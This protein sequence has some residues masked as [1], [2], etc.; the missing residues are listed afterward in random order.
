MNHHKRILI[1]LS[2]IFMLGGCSS[3]I[4]PLPTAEPPTLDEKWKEGTP[5]SVSTEQVQ[6][7]A[8]W[9]QG[10]ED[11]TLTALVERAYSENLT[12]RVAALRIL[13]ARAILGI[14]RSEFYP[15]LDSNSGV[16]RA[17]LSGNAQLSDSRFTNYRTAI[18]T[19]WELDVWGRVQ[20]GVDAANADLNSLDASYENAALSLAAE[21]ATTYIQYRVLQQQLKL[22]HQNIGLQTKS[23]NIAQ[24]LLED[25][26][27]NALDVEQAKAI[28]ADTKALVPDLERNLSQSRN[29]L[30]TL[31]SLTPS[32]VKQWV[33]DNDLSIPVYKEKINV[34]VPIDILRRRPDVKQ[35][36]LSAVAASARVG[37]AQADRYPRF[38]LNG[39][40]ALDVSDGASTLNGGTASDLFDKDSVAFNVGPRISIPLFNAGRLKNRWLAQDAIF[41]QTVESYRLTVFTAIQDVENS[42]AALSNSSIRY[43][44]LSESVRAYER[45][46]EIAQVLYEE[47]DADF[48]NLVDSQ[49]QL[50]IQQQSQITEKGNISISQIAL[51][52]ALGGSWTPGDNDRLADQ[53]KRDLI[54]RNE[55]WNDF[56]GEE[57]E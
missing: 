34:G 31:L 54:D 1:L 37:I 15:T 11:E 35:A 3:L 25:G 51:I 20:R 22:A 28:L 39:S 52:R 57:K 9:W 12:L 8:K 30:I 16:T 5:D 17:G 2:A 6:I 43:F 29:A 47:G 19:A 56:I 14:A 38:T 41:Q 21:V 55:N 10:F 26:S 32:D 44:H 49:R 50:V 18:D 40:L 4:G 24:S 42:L 23:L 36:E 7:D 27:R 48:Q 33:P 46:H 53:V 13:E 45:A